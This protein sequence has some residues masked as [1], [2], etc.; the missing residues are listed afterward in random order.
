[1]DPREEELKALAEAV[2]RH[3]ALARGNPDVGD[4]RG[5]ASSLTNLGRTLY[6]LDRHEEALPVL[7]EAVDV[8]RSLVPLNPTGLRLEVVWD[9]FMHLLE[10]LLA[11]GRREEALKLAA[12]AVELWW[13]MAQSLRHGPVDDFVVMDLFVNL[14]RLS[15]QLLDR[16]LKDLGGRAEPLTAAPEAMEL[17]RALARRDSVALL[18]D[19]AGHLNQLASW[20]TLGGELEV[21]PAAWKAMYDF[22]YGESAVVNEEQSAAWLAVHVFLAA[23]QPVPADPLG[24][25]GSLWNELG[26]KGM[27]VAGPVVREAVERWRDLARSNPEAFHPGLADSFTH[28]SRVLDHLERREDALALAQGAVELRRVLARRDPEAF[29]PGL[30]SSLD[31]LGHRLHGTQRHEEALT[32][33]REAVDLYRAL[34]QRDPDTFQPGLALSLR[35]LGDRLE[36]SRHLEPREE[37]LTAT[38]EAVDL[39]RALAR[40]DPDAF[41]HHLADNLL[42]LGHRSHETARYEEALKATGEAVELRRILRDHRD[43]DAF[44]ADLASS[45]RVLGDR[46]SRQGRHEAALKATQEA[47]ELCR[48]R[49][50][51][52]PYEPQPQRAFASNL[53]DLVHRLRGLGRHGEALKTAAEAVERC[54]ALAQP[55]DHGNSCYD[56]DVKASIPVVGMSLETL[57]ALLTDLGGRAEALTAAPEAVELPWTLAPRGS[58]AL[59]SDLAGHLTRLA[60]WLNKAPVL[61]MAA[62]AAWKAVL[63]VLA[64]FQPG[65]AGRLGHLGSLSNTLGMRPEGPAVR[66]AVEH[67]R[68]LAR[69][70]PEAF[71]PELSDSFSFLSDTLYVRGQREESLTLARGAVELR[72]V[73]AQRDPN[74]LLPCLASSLEVLGHRLHGTQRHEE[75]RTVFEEAVSL[76]QPLTAQEPGA[77][78]SGLA[79]SLHALGVTL[80]KLGRHEE[81]LSAA[82]EAVNLHRDLARYGSEEDQS[83]LAESLELRGETLRELMWFEEALSAAMET[84]EL[85][86]A[87][88][89]LHPERH[90]FSLVMS[91]STLSETLL[92]LERPEEALAPTHEA[93][94]SVWPYLEHHPVYSKLAASLLS[95][96]QE[97]YCGLERPLPADLPERRAALERLQ[98]QGRVLLS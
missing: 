63:L 38:R 64:A 32:A 83:R 53:N 21:S 68:A 48:T 74:R 58:A 75:A 80:S 96:L 56:K 81:A 25:L 52:P 1:M 22:W 51:L 37:A 82:Q 67:W 9:N 14:A 15:I 72:R 79:S 46:L 98:K 57:E 45:L 85:R 92:R 90:Q 69:S 7:Q 28:L 36:A 39:Y 5:L 84:V 13:T 77:F 50:R 10:T 47:V 16:V 33:S 93:L 94:D 23:L 78:K 59:L 6:A 73:L 30:A 95:S 89:R 3:R 29:L 20:S 8:V 31:T 34:A 61:D 91:L 42:V 70:N 2:E 86:R 11:L 44:L 24:H 41:L 40:R 49:M 26:V 4:L 19:L 27:Y 97:L 62:S 87:L 18:L 12:E 54:A 65:P 88:A 43:P 60:E 35:G 17:P 71:H 55:L 76:Y 66:E